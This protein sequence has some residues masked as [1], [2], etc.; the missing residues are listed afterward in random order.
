MF[1]VPCLANSVIVAFA[2][3][4]G[5]GAAGPPAI[6]LPSGYFVYN[7]RDL[8]AAEVRLCYMP[9]N[10]GLTF[11]GQF[12]ASG[13]AGITWNLQ[14]VCME[15]LNQGGT[16]IGDKSA[17]N[18]GTPTNNPNVACAV[19]T[20]GGNEILIGGFYASSVRT[21]WSSPS[22]GFSLAVQDDLTQSSAALIYRIDGASAG[23]TPSYTLASAISWAAIG[24][25]TLG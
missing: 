13:Q 1:P 8:S 23:A 12:S 3:C 21:D 10:G 15:V 11:A 9:N 2:T 16:F 7:S 24:A 19:T 5:Y 4:V 18:A 22:A 20:P 14:V 6:A 25:S 17:T